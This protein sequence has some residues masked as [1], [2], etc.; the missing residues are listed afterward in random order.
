MKAG[1]QVLVPRTSGGYS[2]GKII[3]TCRDT[4]MVEFTI[5]EHY[6]GNAT[7]YPT[8]EIG[9]KIVKISELIKE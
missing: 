4:A 8:D 1:D 2:P 6:R 7:P 3:I 9:T 5:G